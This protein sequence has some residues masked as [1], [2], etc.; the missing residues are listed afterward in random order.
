[1]IK[2]L[3]VIGN[4]LLTIGSVL[5]LGRRTIHFGQKVKHHNRTKYT[6]DEIKPENQEP[7]HYTKPES[8]EDDL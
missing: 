6:T 2:F 1:M 4:A 5:T 8:K 3:F 7:T